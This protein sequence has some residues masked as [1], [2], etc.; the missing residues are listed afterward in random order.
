MARLD[1]KVGEVAYDDI[2]ADTEPAAIPTTIKLAASE[3]PLERGTIMV[4]DAAGGQCKAVSEALTDTSVVYVLADYVEKAEADDVALAYQTG[5]YKSNYL[6][7]DGE[8]TLV[9]ADLEYLRRSG[10][11]TKEEIAAADAEGL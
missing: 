2:F 5:N 8:Y 9:D 11:L 3:K 7:T 1:R 6:K 4:A 10:I